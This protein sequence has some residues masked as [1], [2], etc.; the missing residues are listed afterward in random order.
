MRQQQRKLAREKKKYIHCGRLALRED[1]NL[2]RNTRIHQKRS[3]NSARPDLY[4]KRSRGSIRWILTITFCFVLFI[5][6]L[7]IANAETNGGIVSLDQKMQSFQQKINDGRAHPHAKPL[8]QNQAPAIQAA[9]V[10]QAGILDLGQGPFPRSTFDVHNFWQGP[11]GSDWVLAYAGVK[12][13]PDGTSGL[14]GI[15]LYTET[16]NSQGGFDLHPLG[17]FLAP[18]GTT[19]LAITAQQGDLLTLRSTTGQQLTFNLTSHQF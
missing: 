17:T 13:N 10:R 1:K 11:V 5:C 2:K 3:F 16:V 4:R 8:N 19:A 14:G 15:V 18:N 7:G 9:P 12:M 6:V